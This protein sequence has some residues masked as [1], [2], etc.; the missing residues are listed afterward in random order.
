MTVSYD[1]IKLVQNLYCRNILNLYHGTP[2][3]N[4]QM[5]RFTYDMLLVAISLLM[6]QIL[7]V[8]CMATY[9]LLKLDNPGLSEA[10]AET[11]ESSCR[12]MCS[13]NV[14]GV[15]YSKY[16]ML[17]ITSTYGNLHLIA[18]ALWTTSVCCKANY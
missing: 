4:L 2:I 8:E 10:F 3:S 5:Q 15:S 16:R 13:G 11:N 1:Y 17:C 7:L 9:E 18:D 6:S 12:S 14:S